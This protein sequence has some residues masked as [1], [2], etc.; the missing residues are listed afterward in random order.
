VAAP[1]ALYFTDDDAARRL[2]AADPFALLVGVALDQQVTVQQASALTEGWR[3][4]WLPAP[5]RPYE[6]DPSDLAHRAPPTSEQPRSMGYNASGPSVGTDVAVRLPTIEP[7][8]G[9]VEDTGDVAGGVQ[10]HAMN[11]V[12][13]VVGEVAAR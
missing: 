11:P 8:A 12:L 7:S 3:R 1:D 5:V 2:L 4:R 9:W 10:R 13:G 6:A